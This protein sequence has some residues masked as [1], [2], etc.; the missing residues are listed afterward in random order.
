MVAFRLRHTDKDTI[1]TQ[2]IG[3]LVFP[4]SRFRFFTVE[5]QFHFPCQNLGEKVYGSE[6][7]H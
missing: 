7:K 2:D 3:C 4:F 1:I 5:R 6:K